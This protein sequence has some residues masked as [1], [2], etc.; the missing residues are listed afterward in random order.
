MVKA[1]KYAGRLY[2]GPDWIL[3]VFAAADPHCLFF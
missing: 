1:K 2:V 3:T